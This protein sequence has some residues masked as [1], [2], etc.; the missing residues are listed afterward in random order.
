MTENTGSH[1]RQLGRGAANARA[2]VRRVV[3]EGC[4]CGAKEGDILEMLA[5]YAREFTRL[6]DNLQPSDS[7]HAAWVGG[8]AAALASYTAIRLTPVGEERDRRL[9]TALEPTGWGDRGVG[10]G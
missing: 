2:Y 7:E 9:Q 10:N 4:Q 5:H 8:V 3:K 1:E 6:A